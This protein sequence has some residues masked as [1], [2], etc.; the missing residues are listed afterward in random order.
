MSKY[1]KKYKARDE[2]KQATKEKLL[3][4]AESVFVSSDFKASTF[5]IA[6]HARVAH[7]TIFFHFGNR[8]GLVLSVVRRLVL[9]I[10]DALYEAYKN[11]ANLEELL[12][13]HFETLRAHWSLFKALF[14]GFS[15]FDDETKQQVICLLSVI[16]YYLV[17]AFNMWVDNGLVRTIL[18]QGALVY[19]SFLGDFMFDKKKISEKFIQHLI[20]F[21]RS[22]LSTREESKSKIAGPVIEK[23]QCMSCGMLLHSPGDY[24]MADTSKHFCKYCA[25]DNGTL[26]SFDEVLD[27]MTTFLQKTQVLSPESAHRAAFAVLSKN[28]AWKEYVKKYY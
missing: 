17:E 7:G 11:S 18:W 5:E 2:A 8:D 12:S 6:K 4:I 20:S 14:S 25:D 19:L 16:N 26:R 15:D 24:P 1:S 21:I 27:L 10:T 23:K 13:V 28:P 3:E 9:R 22:P